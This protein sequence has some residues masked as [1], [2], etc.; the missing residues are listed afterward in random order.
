MTVSKNYKKYQ[1]MMEK[2]LEGSLI[3]MKKELMKLRSQVSTKTIP[4]KPAKI[5][6]LRKNIAR[7]LTLIKTKEAVKKA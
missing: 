6:E 1:N 7:I 2:D 5:G 3:E 4:E